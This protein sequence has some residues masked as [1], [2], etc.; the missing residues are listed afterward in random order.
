MPG[1]MRLA[2]ARAMKKP[3][4]ERIPLTGYDRLKERDYF[5]VSLL[6]EDQRL[7]VQS[8]QEDGVVGLM[9]EG[10]GEPN[11]VRLQYDHL[12]DYELEIIHYFDEL[13]LRYSRPWW[14]LLI[15]WPR[16]R[17]ELAKFRYAIWA[18]ARVPLPRDDRMDLLRWAYDWTMEQDFPN[19]EF[20]LIGFL[21]QKHGHLVFRHP[22]EDRLLRHYKLISD[23]LVSSGDFVDRQLGHYA[24]APRGLATLDKFAQDTTN[25]R[26]NIQQQKAMSKLTRWLVFVAFIQAAAAVYGAL[27]P[28]ANASQPPATTP[29]PPQTAPL[30]W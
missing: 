16:C 24:L 8:V 4:P 19:P 12:P 28:D 9:F 27:W 3:A 2:L 1:L 5:Q 22:D 21:I 15:W 6:N 23:S 18:F 29:T 10:L 26:D 25:H 7:L 13:E 14:F 17:W 11:E 30:P 20:E